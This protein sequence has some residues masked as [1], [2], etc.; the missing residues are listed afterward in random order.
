MVPRRCSCVMT[1]KTPIAGGRCECGCSPPARPARSPSATTRW[2]P[3]GTAWRSPRSPTPGHC[4]SARIGS[5]PR[6]SAPICS[7]ASIS[8]ITAGS[9]ESRA[10]ARG[11]ASGCPRG[12]RR[13]RRGS[14]RTRRG[15]RRPG[16]ALVRR[17]AGRRGGHPLRPAVGWLLRHGRR[18]ARQSPLGDQTSAGSDRQRHALGF[19]GGGRVPAELRR[20]YGFQPAPRCRL[21]ALGVYDVLA[22][23]AP[24]F[25]GWGLAV[26]EALAAEAGRGRRRRAGGRPGDR[27]VAPRGAPRHDAG[28]RRRRRRSTRRC[29]PGG[30]AVAGPP[31]GRGPAGCVRLSS[32][33]LR[34]ADN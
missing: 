4:W 13:R 23:Q 12:L 10:R 27:G 15:H 9:P 19:V 1:P 33:R 6:W 16:M 25:A 29:Q 17:A 30:A 32:V 34:R 21:G 7:S 2:W 28:R 26:A 8:T 24:R 11:S 31:A 3:R 18:L 5:R 20:I 22:D 14:A